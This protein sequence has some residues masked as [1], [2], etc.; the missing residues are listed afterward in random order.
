[1]AS[2]AAAAS[3]APAPTARE[4]F[5]GTPPRRRWFPTCRDPA[6]TSRRTTSWYVAAAV[7]SAENPAALHHT[8]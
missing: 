8:L 6:S 3:W 7:R 4:P 2:R 1:V 5:D